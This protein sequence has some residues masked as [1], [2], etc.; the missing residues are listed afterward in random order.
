MINMASG[1]VVGYQDIY[2]FSAFQVGTYVVVVRRLPITCATLAHTHC[3]RLAL[4][5]PTT[6]AY[7][8]TKASAQHA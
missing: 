6:C 4:N 8:R 2:W 3:A 5:M 1:P 7:E